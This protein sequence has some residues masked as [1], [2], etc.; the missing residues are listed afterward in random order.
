MI[1][2]LKL[3]TLFVGKMYLLGQRYL[4]GDVKITPKNGLM[5]TIFNVE[6]ECEN[7]VRSKNN[8][9]KKVVTKGIWDFGQLYLSF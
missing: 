3:H 5:L 7:M 6:M 9:H 2:F 1:L 8:T 4:T